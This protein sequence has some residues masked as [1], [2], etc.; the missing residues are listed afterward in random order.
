MRGSKLR[1][2]SSRVSPADA[3]G[4]PPC[5]GRPAQCFTAARGGGAWR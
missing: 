1:A 2:P 3:L 4:G 5:D